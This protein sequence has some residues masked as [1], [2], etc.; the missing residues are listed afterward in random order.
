MHQLTGGV[1]LRIAKGEKH[2]KIEGWL[3]AAEKAWPAPAAIYEKTSAVPAGFET[4]LYPLPNGE[5]A[6]IESEK[7]DGIIEVRIER[8][9]KTVRDIFVPSSHAS[10]N[11]TFEGRMAWMRFD[12]Q[13]LLSVALVGGRRLV[14]EEAGLELIL[15]RSANLCITRAESGRYRIYADLMNHPALQVEMNGAKSALGPGQTIVI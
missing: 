2:P 9:G 10:E 15:G 8:G 5:E 13:G 3:A 6:T 7:K 4:L 11:L 14:S 1:D 12:E